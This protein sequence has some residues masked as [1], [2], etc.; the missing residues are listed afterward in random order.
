MTHANIVINLTFFEI[1]RLSPQLPP[2]AH[3]TILHNAS[4][5]DWNLYAF[6]TKK[7]NFITTIP[8]IIFYNIVHVNTQN[9]NI[10]YTLY[11]HDILLGD[12]FTLPSPSPNIIIGIST[13]TPPRTHI[14]TYIHMHT[15][16]LTL[17]KSW[18]KYFLTT[19]FRILKSRDLIPQK[20]IL[21]S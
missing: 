10:H 12:I 4:K 8:L 17:I 1:L 3:T 19:Y 18:K 21:P 20:W 2:T 15:H 6:L 9:K 16:T 13:S 5:N 14:H 11:L 7:L